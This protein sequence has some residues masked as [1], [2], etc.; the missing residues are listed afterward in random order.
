MLRLSGS[1][2]MVVEANRTNQLCIEECGFT[3]HLCWELE[4]A[5]KHFE[6]NTIFLMHLNLLIRLCCTSDLC[7]FFLGIAYGTVI[8]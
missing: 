7:S 8:Q 3:L 2:V 5:V 1:M 6:L 4:L